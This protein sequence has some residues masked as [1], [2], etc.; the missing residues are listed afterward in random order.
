M[1]SNGEN[2]LIK[3]VN[4]SRTGIGDQ[5]GGNGPGNDLKAVL[6]ARRLSE[7]IELLYLSWPDKK[8]GVGLKGKHKNSWKKKY[9]NDIFYLIV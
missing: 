2:V 8:A 9:Q 4:V 6:K 7:R 3:C 1:N 5:T